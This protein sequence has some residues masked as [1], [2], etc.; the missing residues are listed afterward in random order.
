MQTGST[1]AGVVLLLTLAEP[2]IRLGKALNG[3]SAGGGV[4]RFLQ[5][6]N[7]CPE[8]GM[9]LILKVLELAVTSLPSLLLLCRLPA[10]FQP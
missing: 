10:L 6:G 3:A 1:E 8:K 2:S 5:S 9:L 4:L 7:F